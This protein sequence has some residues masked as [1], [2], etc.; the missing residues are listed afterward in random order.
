MVATFVAALTQFIIYSRSSPELYHL[1][2]GIF[3]IFVTVTPVGFR[4]AL[5]RVLICLCDCRVVNLVE[6]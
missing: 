2:Q 4:S 5:L 1:E 3:Q 6:S